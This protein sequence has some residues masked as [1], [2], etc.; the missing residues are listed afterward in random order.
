MKVSKFKRSKS[1]KPFSSAAFSSPLSVTSLHFLLLGAS[2]SPFLLSH[3]ALGGSR[4]W[5]LNWD[6]DGN[7]VYNAR[8][9]SLSFSNVSWYFT[10]ANVYFVYEPLSLLFKAVFCSLFGLNPSLNFLCNAFLHSLVT[11]LAYN[12]SLLVP[13]ASFSSSSASTSASHVSYSSYAA[14]G[15][16]VFATH[17]LRAEVVSWLSAQSYLL[18]SLFSLISLTLHLRSSSRPTLLSVAFFFAAVL[19]KSIAVSVCALFVLRDVSLSRS[20]PLSSFFL[21]FRK[22]LFY[23]LIA[24]AA[25]G[26][27]ILGNAELG[28]SRTDSLTDFELLLS[29]LHSFSF[30]I[31]AT[32]N[33]ASVTMF[34]PTQES[35]YR[36]HSSFSASLCIATSLLLLTFAALSALFHLRSPRAGTSL[37]IM[38]AGT[39][40]A[41]LLPTF[42]AQHGWPMVGANRYGKVASLLSPPP[43]LP[44]PLPPTSL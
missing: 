26:K 19:C 38:F 33:P 43:S 22:N 2:L 31:Y 42:L 12:L 36:D 1:S 35:H 18:S 28:Y 37:A 23:I 32:L 9:H 4:E 39:Y 29:K 21:S 14:L 17:P 11:L 30:Y 25:A 34:Y 27:Q 24:L 10:S 16:A 5:L 41:L 8:V 3:G 44:S 6:D 40:I 13:S 15:A 7:F 20:S